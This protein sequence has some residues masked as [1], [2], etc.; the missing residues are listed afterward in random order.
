MMLKRCL[1]YSSLLPFYFI[2][3]NATVRPNVTVSRGSQGPTM[4]S[5]WRHY[6]RAFPTG[7]EGPQC[8]NKMALLFPVRTGGTWRASV[9]RT[10][11]ND[12]LYVSVQ[13]SWRKLRMVETVRHF[14][15]Q[16]VYSYFTPTTQILLPL[17]SFWRENI[18]L[19][20]SRKAERP[21]V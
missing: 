18:A 13:G 16:L 11:R 17:C 9:Y 1:K 10:Y 4:G 7:L 5:H 20:Y 3:F 8:R 19:R 15:L 14:H 21:N 6:M 12:I 2:P